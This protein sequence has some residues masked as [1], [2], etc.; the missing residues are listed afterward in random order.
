MHVII[1]FEDGDMNE[2]VEL[3]D[4]I[5]LVSLKRMIVGI[6]PRMPFVRMHYK[7]VE[8]PTDGE[9]GLVELGHAVEEGG[10]I[11]FCIRPPSPRTILQTGLTR[12]DRVATE[13]ARTDSDGRPLLSSDEIVALLT[14]PAGNG[15]CT[16]R[17]AASLPVGPETPA[18][19]TG[20]DS[21]HGFAFDMNSMNDLIETGLPVSLT[22]QES[23]RFSQLFDD[24]KTNA[25]LK[26]NFDQ[27]MPTESVIV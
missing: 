25:A 3:D 12:V 2:T 23:A 15:A 1:N 7:G 4:H 19:R 14:R 8:L 6:E 13:P 18:T 17:N 26:A 22:D 9:A 24:L 5:P 11:T 10:T 27:R 21:E 20:F 16:S